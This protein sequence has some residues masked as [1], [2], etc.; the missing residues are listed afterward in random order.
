MSENKFQFVKLDEK[1]SEHIASPEYSYWGSVFRKFFSSKLAI[2]MLV[3][4]LIIVLMSIVQP[5]ISGYSPMDTPNINNNAM[6]YIRPNSTYWFGTDDVGNSLF[7]ALWAGTRNSLLIAVTST[8]ISTTLGVIVGMFW[9]FSR[10]VD[11]VLIE[12]Y[13]VIANIPYL[14]L[15]MVL[16]YVLGKG[17]PQMIFSLTVTS[18]LG[19]AYF[20][21][22]QV[23]IIRDR[24]YNLASQC[25]GTSLTKMIKHNIF[26]YLISVIMTSISRD[27]PSFISYEVFLSYVG[28]GLG[29]D[30]ASLGRMVQSYSAYMLSAPYLFWIPVAVSAIIAVS[31]YLVGQTLADASDP[32]TH[33]I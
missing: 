24:E 19:T 8:A 20:I 2:T 29:M 28:N 6:K 9:G 12:V 17:I 13:N 33:M 26:P 7:D 27:I 18:W 15:V 21:R 10:K 25:L 1:A 5:M 4:V 3:I 14:L 16:M 31:L 22:V 32:R 30:T 23:M 11:K